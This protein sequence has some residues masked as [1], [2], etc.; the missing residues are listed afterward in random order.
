MTAR[1]VPCLD[2]CG[3]LKWS[4]G[5]IALRARCLGNRKLSK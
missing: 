3:L 1:S 2:D 5:M 4:V